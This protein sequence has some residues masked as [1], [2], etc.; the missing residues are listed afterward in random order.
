MK[1]LSALEKQS[2]HGTNESGFVSEKATPEGMLTIDTS[3]LIGN[4]S[5]PEAEKET[6]KGIEN[7]IAIKDDDDKPVEIKL[8]DLSDDDDGVQDEVAF[9]EHEKCKDSSNSNEKPLIDVDNSPF[10]TCGSTAPKQELF[11]KKVVSVL[12]CLKIVSN[13][14][15]QETFQVSFDDSNI[16]IVGKME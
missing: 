3:S 16:I 9:S 14:L 12:K 7:L 6:S 4:A 5:K 1:R 10:Q 13:H 15:T 8:V 2:N 11:S